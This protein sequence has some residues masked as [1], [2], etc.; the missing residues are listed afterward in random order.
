MEEAATD[1]VVVGCA[2]CGYDRFTPFVVQNSFQ[3]VKC[4]E[5][6]FV[7]VN[8]RPSLDALREMYADYHSSRIGDPELWRSYMGRVFSA[9]AD[10]LQR[11]LPEGASVLDVGCG[12]GYFVEEAAA[13]GFSAKGVDLT[14]NTVAF[15]RDRGLDVVE[16][17]V[18]TAGFDDGSFDAVTMFYVLEHLT[19]PLAT[20]R[21]VLQVLKPGGVLLLRVPHTTPIVTLLD[22]FSIENNLYDP[23]F[24]LSDFSPET[25]KRTLRQAGFG[26]VRTSIG[27]ATMPP[28][29]PARLLSLVSTGVAEALYRAS[30]GRV[31]LPGV[32]KTTVAV[33]PAARPD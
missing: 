24:H 30:G 10:E 16:G 28:A 4:E 18:E 20:L 3:V 1:I 6:G 33:K 29:L 14:E 22:L 21:K 7:Y 23:P 17:T 9:A 27:G 2:L 25:M 31:L 5:C 19:E 8:P 32:S 12:H 13:R 15:A 11:L 26:G